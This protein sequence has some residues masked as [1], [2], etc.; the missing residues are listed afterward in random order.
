M[1]DH[2]FDISRTI[3][4]IVAATFDEKVIAAKARELFILS[5]V[6]SRFIK[7]KRILIRIIAV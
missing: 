7:Y 6:L 5:L 2:A 1:T 4:S 3:N